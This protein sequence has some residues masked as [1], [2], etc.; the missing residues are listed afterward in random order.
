MDPRLPCESRN[1]SSQQVVCSPQS[2][3]QSKNRSYPSQ[4]SMINAFFVTEASEERKYRN[5]PMNGC[6]ETNSA[7]W[8]NFN[9]FNA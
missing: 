1:D 9:P 4:W 3:L 7:V 5:K 2:P 8:M 6:I